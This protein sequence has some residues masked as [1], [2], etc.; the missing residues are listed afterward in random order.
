L[1]IAWYDNEWGYSSRVADLIER[2]EEM[3]GMSSDFNGGE[4]GILIFA[5]AAVIACIAV[6]VYEPRGTCFVWLNMT[7]LPIVL[8]AE[9]F[10]IPRVI[11][12]AVA[13]GLVIGRT[14][15]PWVDRYALTETGLHISL[16]GLVAQSTR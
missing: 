4:A 7:C 1:V 14:D 11:V 9:V 15:F 10:R 5:V 12:A 16:A 8:S 6:L 2:L 3:D 13:A